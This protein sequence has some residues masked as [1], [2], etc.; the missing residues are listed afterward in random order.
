M[1][2]ETH[3]AHG[4]MWPLMTAQ[5]LL[6]AAAGAQPSDP[7]SK[8]GWDTCISDSDCTKSKCNDKDP[9][10][11]LSAECPAWD[12][13]RG[14]PISVCISGCGRGWSAESIAMGGERGGAQSNVTAQTFA[15][16]SC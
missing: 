1:K 11:T 6:A 10:E 8:Y 14:I 4:P 3:L 2:P 12:S 9:D 13:N 16:N 7:C 15:P 5:L